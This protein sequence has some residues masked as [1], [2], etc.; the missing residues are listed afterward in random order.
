MK[1]L[2]FNKMEVINAGDLETCVYA[3]GTLM[4]MGIA[5]M[6]TPAGTALILGGALLGFVCT[7]TMK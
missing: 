6:F 4:T 5:S 3:S 1:N 7:Q 2:E